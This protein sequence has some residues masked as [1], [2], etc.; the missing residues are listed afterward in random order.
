MSLTT[1]WVFPDIP[2]KD[3][4][5]PFTDKR[6]SSSELDYQYRSRRLSNPERSVVVKNV[7]DR[8]VLQRRYSAPSQ[9]PIQPVIQPKP[10]KLITSKPPRQ[11]GRL[12]SNTVSS[13][14]TSLETSM[15]SLSLKNTSIRVSNET[16]TE[17]KGLF[18]WI[19]KVI[20]SDNK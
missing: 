4:P 12:R 8:P 6:S 10:K 1:D 19:K 18:D 5:A 15:S 7:G 16:L 17:R 20:R 11:F 13:S 14:R 3:S 9:P 2:R